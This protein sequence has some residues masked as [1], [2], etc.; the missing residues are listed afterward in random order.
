MGAANNAEFR[1]TGSGIGGGST[2][3]EV[4]DGLAEGDKIMSTGRPIR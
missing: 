2:D 3:I 4:T 1:K